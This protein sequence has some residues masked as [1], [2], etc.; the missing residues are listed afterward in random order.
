MT[1]RPISP[2]TLQK[3]REVGQISKRFD[4]FFLPVKRCEKR[5]GDRL[6]GDNR[7]GGEGEE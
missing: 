3:G 5:E 2:G 7:G 1:D 4:F 6:E